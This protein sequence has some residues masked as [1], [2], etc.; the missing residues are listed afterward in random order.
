MRSRHLALFSAV[1]ILG[2]VAMGAV[3]GSFDGGRPQETTTLTGPGPYRGSEPSAG[4]R[5]PVFRFAMSSTGSAPD[6]PA[7]AAQE[8]S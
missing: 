5:M 6:D 8:T 4:L 7:P 2:A 1:V 3:L